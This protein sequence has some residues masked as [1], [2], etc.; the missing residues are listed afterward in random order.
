MTITSAFPFPELYSLSYNEIFNW[1]LFRIASR[2]ML[3]QSHEGRVGLVSVT[4][5]PFLRLPRCSVSGVSTPDVCVLRRVCLFVTPRTV[6]HQAPSSMGFPCQEYWTRLQ[7][8][9]PGDLPSPGRNPCLLCLLHW[10]VDSLLTGNP[11]ALL[12]LCSVGEEASGGPLMGVKAVAPSL[13]GARDQCRGRQFFHEPGWRVWLR[14]DSS[15]LRF[16][17][18]Y[19]MMSAPPQTI[20]H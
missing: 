9:P 7:F 6:V 18:Y 16:S 1:G 17:Y 20:S 5:C 2:L 15:T 11:S 4:V 13:S 19:V 12:P 14:G 3:W 10:Q 8:P